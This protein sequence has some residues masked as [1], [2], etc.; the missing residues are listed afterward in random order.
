MT[1]SI[2]T[3]FLDLKALAALERLKFTTKHRIEGSYSGRHTSRQQGGAG[4]FVDY[5]DYTPGEDLRRIDW[6]VYARTQ[7]PYVRLFQD[8]TNL[9][10]TIVLDVSGSMRF[11]AKSES[12]LTG[13]KL[14]YAQY[15]ATAFS[16]V[17][18]KGQDQVGLAVA[19]KKLVESLSPGSTPV[20]LA[21]LYETIESVETTSSRALAPSLRELFECMRG[22]GVLLILSDFLSE[23]LEE[24][25]AT[26]RLFRHRQFEVI[27]VHLVDPGEEQ[28]PAGASFRFDGLEGEGRIDCSPAEIRDEYARQFAQHLATVRSYALADGCDYRLVSTSQSYLSVLSGFLVERNG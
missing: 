24:C 13:S 21:K 6:K 28:L 1:S 10:C 18:S 5:R 20:H 7:K 8:E 26:L 12:D 19:G 22:R 11:G 2:T 17:I 14:E 23:D 16:H 15:L 27:L 4:E 3:R 9:L 25:F